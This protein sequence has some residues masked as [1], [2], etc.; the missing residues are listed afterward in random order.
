MIRRLSFF[1]FAVFFIS[2]CATLHYSVESDQF[3]LDPGGAD[4]A[5]TWQQRGRVGAPCVARAFTF[6]DKALWGEYIKLERNCSY[7]GRPASLYRNLLNEKMQKIEVLQR[8]AAGAYEI[9]RYGTGEGVFYF[10]SSYSGQSNLFILDYSGKIA[11][12]LCDRC[13]VIAPEKRVKSAYEISLVK[14]SVLGD[15]FSK[16]SAQSSEWLLN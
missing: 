4:I 6:Q 9:I 16:E 12:K 7:N 15:V 2:G 10:I 5:V 1:F 13:G 11:A 8:H 14:R 3:R